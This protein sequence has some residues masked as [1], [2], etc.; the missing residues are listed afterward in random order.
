MWLLVKAKAKD[1]R[2]LGD[3]DTILLSVVFL[4]MF[5]RTCRLSQHRLAAHGCR[6]KGCRRGIVYI[7][8]SYSWEM[9]KP[10]P[11]QHLLC[12]TYGR[13]FLINTSSTPEYLRLLPW[14]PP[15]TPPY[16]I[17]KCAVMCCGNWLK[18]QHDAFGADE[19]C[20]F[21]QVYNQF[22][23]L[24]AVEYA[25]HRAWCR[26]AVICYLVPTCVYNSPR[27]QMQMPTHRG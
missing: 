15:P 10:P 1:V 19:N 13:A 24:V 2:V 25:V 27:E 11:G 16:L 5:F 22:I 17:M 21:F 9:Q 20:I 14:T 4:Y 12:I 23:V 3:S 6:I 18:V 8:S 7:S 26:D